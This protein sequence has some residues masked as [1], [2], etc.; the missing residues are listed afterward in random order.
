MYFGDRLIH[1]DVVPWQCGGEIT[2]IQVE[3]SVGR[4]GHKHNQE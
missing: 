1:E 2:R 4:K 3:D